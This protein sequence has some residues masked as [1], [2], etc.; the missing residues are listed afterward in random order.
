MMVDK[1]AILKLHLTKTL[2]GIAKGDKIFSIHLSQ[3]KAWV[4]HVETSDHLH[5]FDLDWTGN[6]ENIRDVQESFKQQ[7]LNHR[8]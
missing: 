8:C 4:W 1:A 2:S 3:N 7:Y 6:E 5:G